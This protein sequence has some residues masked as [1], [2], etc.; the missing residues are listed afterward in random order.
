MP[1]NTLPALAIY[2]RHFQPSPTLP[3]PFAMIGVALVCAEN[4][5]TVGERFQVAVPETY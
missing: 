4:D 3:E 1:Q 2:R 5:E